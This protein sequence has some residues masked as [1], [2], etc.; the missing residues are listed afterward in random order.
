MFRPTDKTLSYDNRESN[1]IRSQYAELR[2]AW[3][4]AWTAPEKTAILRKLK[5]LD[6]LTKH[7]HRDPTGSWRSR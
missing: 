1:F 4:Q 7:H 5:N 2:N 3:N 6:H